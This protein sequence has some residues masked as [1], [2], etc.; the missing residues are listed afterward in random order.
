MLATIQ[1][2]RSWLL[3]SWFRLWLRLATLFDGSC[4]ALTVSCSSAWWFEVNHLFNDFWFMT[5]V[6]AVP[7]YKPVPS[8]RGLSFGYGKYISTGCPPS[9][10]CE[11]WVFTSLSFWVSLILFLAAMPF[12]C[13]V[14]FL[15]C[16]S[17]LLVDVLLLYSI[18][19]DG[20]SYGDVGTI[21][22]YWVACHHLVCAIYTLTQSILVVKA[23][24]VPLCGFVF[25]LMSSSLTSISKIR[26]PNND[27]LLPTAGAQFEP[28]PLPNQSDSENTSGP[29][30]PT[31]SVPTFS[32][33]LILELGGSC[34]GLNP[35]EANRTN[36]S[37]AG[38]VP[39]TAQG[40]E[41]VPTPSEGQSFP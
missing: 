22:V 20:R 33:A 12:P 6:W 41:H 35:F 32:E 40:T 29:Q 37:P 36:P 21:C 34:S 38:H 1:I 27:Y 3:C 17:S 39:T 11:V 15:F 7:F 19:H 16:C 13:C 10:T 2:C 9:T 5:A 26:A 24:C 8:Q 23:C 14:L 28:S 25:L 18:T 4:R 31:S 30:R